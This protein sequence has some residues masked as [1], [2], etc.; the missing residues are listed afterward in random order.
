MVFSCYRAAGVKKQSLG[1]KNCMESDWE[2]SPQMRLTSKDCRKQFVT[3]TIAIIFALP[4]VARAS[5]EITKPA[6][7]T[8]RS[9]PAAKDPAG[10]LPDAPLP[11][12]SDDATSPQSSTVSQTPDGQSSQM[13]RI[14]FFFYP[15]PN[16]KY[17]TVIQPGMAFHPLSPGEKMIY[18]IRE[19]V[20]PSE[21]AIVVLDAGWNHLF[22]GNPKYG[23]DSG[24]FAS[25]IG[26]IAIRQA[27]THVISDGI[28]ASLFHQDE[29]YF[30]KGPGTKLKGRAKY[31]LLSVLLTRGESGNTQVDASGLL[32]RA[33][34][35][36][37]TM[38]YYP[39][40]SANGRVAAE[41]FGWSLAGELG[42][43]TYLEF[44]P[45]IWL[46]MFPSKKK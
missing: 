22:N 12:A 11:S 24:A 20:V 44:W 28:Y 43:N 8:S 41:S 31:V 10:A 4:I 3:L 36:A 14:G 33:T 25:R 39:K 37:L 21:L 18:S 45:D 38:A 17:T 6:A 1:R 23:T 29:R 35:S 27:T 42:A 19:S 46:H 13:Q 32:G 15:N 5:D 2:P 26:A 16:S 9:A 34:G 30:R 40:A 7:S